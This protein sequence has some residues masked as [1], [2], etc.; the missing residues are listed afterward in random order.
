MSNYTISVRHL[1]RNKFDFGLK[2]YPIFDE[3]Y[4]N[5]LNQNILNYYFLYE[6]GLETAELF[7]HQLNNKMQLIMPYYNNLYN[8][9]KIALKNLFKNNEVKETLMRNLEINTTQKNTNN[10]ENDSENKSKNVL[11]N[12][13]QGA[14]KYEN[15]DNFNYANEINLNSDKSKD[16]SK[17]VNDLLNDIMNEEN[18]TKVYEGLTGTSYITELANIKNNIM[19]IDMLIINELRD[20]FMTIF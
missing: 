11:Q 20:L 12:S 19:N 9:Q 3:N 15:I 1:I 7:K 13:P 16:T 6:I 10:I 4:R 18:Y 8:A 5:T 17:S 14:L 2:N